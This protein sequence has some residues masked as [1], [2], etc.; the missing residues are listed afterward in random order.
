MNLHQTM[1]VL[2]CQ[3]FLHTHTYKGMKRRKLKVLASKLNGASRARRCTKRALVLARRTSSSARPLPEY[4]RSA[5]LPAPAPGSRQRVSSG[6]VGALAE[7][8]ARP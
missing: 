6:A 7:P 5:P 1:R 8:N 3:K 4:S 2:D